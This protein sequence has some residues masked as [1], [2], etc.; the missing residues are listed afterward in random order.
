LENYT[1]ELRSCLFGREA[2]SKSASPGIKR[3]AE[4]LKVPI[5]NDIGYEGGL[6]NKSK[7]P[8]KTANLITLL[9]LIPPA[10]STKDICD[11][12]A[13]INI[14]ATRTL[15]DIQKR[16]KL[17]ILLI[18]HQLGAELFDQLIANFKV[19][20]NY[21]LAIL[22]NIVYSIILEHTKCFHPPS[23]MTLKPDLE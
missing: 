10:V 20:D 19:I 13:A 4:K 14:Q 8:E 1:N 17:F 2:Y 23:T 11:E 15:A 16:D 5:K 3:I 9:C 18:K 22:G 21:K 6:L 12:I 7:N